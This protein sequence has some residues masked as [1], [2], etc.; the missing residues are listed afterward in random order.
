MSEWGYVIAGWSV[1]VGGL[2]T[3]AASILLRA[4][5]LTPRVAPERRR[6]MESSGE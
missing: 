3:Y 6:W 4:R 2:A 1:V 5:R